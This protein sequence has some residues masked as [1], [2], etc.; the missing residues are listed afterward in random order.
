MQPNITADLTWNDH[1]DALV[2]EN[3]N[4]AGVNV[5]IIVAREVIEDN[6]G[7]RI[8]AALASG[9]EVPDAVRNRVH[10]E[11]R[12]RFASGAF[13]KPRDGFDGLEMRITTDNAGRFS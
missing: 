3:L 1:L 7:N 8:A 10:A 9:G 5:R 11:V 12:D 6:F 13:T 4:R 2:G